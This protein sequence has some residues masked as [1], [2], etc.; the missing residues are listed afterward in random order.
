MWTK[1]A[2]GAMALSAVGGGWRGEFGAAPAPGGDPARGRALYQQDCAI[3]HR[4]DGS[5]SSR[6]PD[7]RSSGLASVD[8]QVSTGRMPRQAD[9][10]SQPKRDAYS[11][12]ETA[13][14]LSYVQQFVSGPAVPDPDTNASVPEGERLYQLNCAACHQA[15]GAGGVLAHNTQVPALT[16]SSARQVVEAMRTGPGEMPLFTSGFTDNEASEI[17]AYVQYLHHPDDRGG[18]SLGHLG[19]VPEG[20]VAIGLGLGAL[21][22][23]ARWLGTREPAGRS[24]SG[25][26]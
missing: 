21:A 15:A 12:A 1:L 6:G 18:Y 22:L 10:P 9:D 4:P 26:D 13:D 8:F 17:A 20:L 5:G 3:C 25:I 24:G 11:Q 7:I 16:H 23:V 14:L 19:P 2:I